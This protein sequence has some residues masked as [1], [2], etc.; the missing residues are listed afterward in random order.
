MLERLSLTNFKC[1]RRIEQM[2]FAPITGLFGAN[3]SG[4]TS[5][6]QLLLMLKQT[7][8]S[9]DR[10][11][12]LI[13]GDER[14]PVNLGRFK[15][16][17]YA[18]GTEA[19]LTWDMQWRL[20]KRLTIREPADPTK[21]LFQGDRLGFESEVRS[22]SGRL[23]VARMAYRFANCRFA[24][25]QIEDSPG[26]Y[27]LTG[28]GNGFT[29]TRT[30]GRPWELP[31]P[32]KCYGF[33]DQARAYFQNAEF[34]ADLQLAFEKL[35]GQMYYLGP[36]REYPRR[37]Y[38]WAGAE[39]GDMGP[40]GGRVVDAILAARQKGFK[41]SRGRGYKRVTLEKYVAM[42]LKKLGLVH[43]FSVEEIAKESNLY[44]V[45]VQKSPSSPE[46]LITDVGFGVS[47]VLPA[48]VLCYYVPEGSTIILEQPEIHLHP[49][50]QAALADVF[51]DAA[52][53]RSLQIILESHSEHLLHRL[54]RRVAEGPDNGGI[55]NEMAKLYFCALD[56]G[57][58]KLTPLKLDLY[59]KIDNW[60]EDF[61]GDRFGEAA[62]RERAALQRQIG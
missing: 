7:V 36:L 13:F 35:F 6:L 30:R 43:N 50:V 44:R 46:V 15:D 14:T 42:W 62:A 5:I 49:S 56:G 53:K 25:D 12:A 47:Q 39:P 51:I 17:A 19:P 10:A 57:E 23:A 11:Q 18:H 31:S 60:P 26:K 33:P 38:P 37:E 34:L 1:W 54:Q 24:M 2:E 22:I 48:L 8:E 3:S 4:K 29:F 61:F 41:I 55:S 21:I 9:P 58:A 59:G 40:G 20:P 28:E 32:V 27:S 16:V 52:Q 45:R